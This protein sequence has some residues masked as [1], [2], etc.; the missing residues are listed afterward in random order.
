MHV[1]AQLQWGRST[2]CGGG[3]CLEVAVAGG[4]VFAR[5]AEDEVV[6]FAS[7]AWKEFVTG[8][9]RGQFVRPAE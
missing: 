6:F 4:A 2:Y 5:V 8:V 7:E 9:K 1:S 3:A